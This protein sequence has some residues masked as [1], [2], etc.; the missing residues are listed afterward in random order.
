M[1]VKVSFSGRIIE[2]HFPSHLTVKDIKDW[3]NRR[4]KENISKGTYIRLRHL[5]PNHVIIRDTETIDILYKMNKIENHN[6]HPDCIFLYVEIC[7]KNDKNNCNI[8]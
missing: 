8:L 1:L 7:T 5:I 2:N 6:S 3:I 4:F